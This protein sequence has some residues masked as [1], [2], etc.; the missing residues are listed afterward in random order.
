MQYVSVNQIS[1]RLL[2]IEVGVPQGSI[3]APTLFLIYVN[4][5]LSYTMYS[6]SFAYADDTVFMLESE[7]LKTLSHICNIDL[8][9]IGKWCEANRMVL[10]TKKSNYMILK[11]SRAINLDLNLTINNCKL[12]QVSTTKLLGFTLNDS[13]TWTEHIDQV[14]LKI[15]KNIALFQNCREFLD[16]KSARDFYFRYIYCYLI[17]GIRIYGNLSPRY[18]LDRIFLL[19]KRA[20]RLIANVNHI[21]YHLIHTKDLH[22]SLNLMPFP[23]LAG[24]F[25]CIFGYQVYHSLCPDFILEDFSST[26]CRNSQRNTHFLQFYNDAL[27]HKVASAFNSLPHHIPSASKL[28]IFGSLLPLKCTA[29]QAEYICCFF[30]FFCTLSFL[31]LSLHEKH[32][33]NDCG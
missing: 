17:Y 4:D 23:L 5:L 27:R 8:Y 21:P 12:Q 14:C 15:N 30:F 13:L 6:K 2:P 16:R 18:L 24:Q 32:C 25:T 11:P 10:N 29:H 22:T 3:L 19:Q 28:V 20:M 1:S 26:Q 33:Y 7:D 31:F 9:L